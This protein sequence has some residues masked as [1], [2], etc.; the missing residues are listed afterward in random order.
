M[1][2]PLPHLISRYLGFHLNSSIFEQAGPARA[3]AAGMA[4]LSISSSP[5]FLA[6]APV[7]DLGRAK[8]L[9]TARGGECAPCS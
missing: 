8:D 4:A 2:S 5:F 9:V 1:L 6:S 7:S 3:A